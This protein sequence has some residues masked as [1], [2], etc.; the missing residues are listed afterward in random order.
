MEKKQQQK[1]KKRLY[2]IKALWKTA[3]FERD[4]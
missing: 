3:T 4:F 1:K 2:S